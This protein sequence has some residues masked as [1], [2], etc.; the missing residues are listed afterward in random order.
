[1]KANLENNHEI[2]NFFCQK[3]RMNAAVIYLFDRFRLS[4]TLRLL[5]MDKQQG[6]FGL[7]TIL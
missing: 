7:V 6:E 2:Y 1:M 3:D 4:Q 5:K